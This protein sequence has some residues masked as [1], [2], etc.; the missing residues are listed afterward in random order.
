MKDK[1]QKKEWEKTRTIHGGGKVK[2]NEKLLRISLKVR[3]AIA[4]MKQQQ[5]P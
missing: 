1:N 5:N 4:P 3:E 2:T